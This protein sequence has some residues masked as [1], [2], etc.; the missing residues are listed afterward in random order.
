[1]PTHAASQASSLT[2]ACKII[3]KAADRA[4]ASSHDRRRRAKEGVARRGK[5]R[6]ADRDLMG[7]SEGRPMSGSKPLKVHVDRQRC[8]GHARCN[9]IAPELF[10]L[11][12]LGNAREL[13][14]GTV[15]SGLEDRAWLA[16]ANCPEMA[17]EVAEE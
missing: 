5:L 8:Q 16:K 6:H 10:E 9:A 4:D 11:D 7:P 1:V 3:A 14:D 13:G 15:P 17:I 2:K 12:E